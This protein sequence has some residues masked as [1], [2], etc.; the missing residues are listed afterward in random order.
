MPLLL[1]I[2]LHESSVT[3]AATKSSKLR[4]KMCAKKR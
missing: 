3:I 2:V 1:E 4:E